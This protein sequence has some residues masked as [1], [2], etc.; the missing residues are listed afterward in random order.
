M[1][2]FGI[3]LGGFL[4]CLIGDLIYE[5]PHRGAYFLV[6]FITTAVSVVGYYSIGIVKF[7]KRPEQKDIVGDIARVNFETMSELKDIESKPKIRK[8][9][10]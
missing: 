10:S 6:G 4:T 9:R 1:L 3:V 8:I 7:L 2:P 5:I